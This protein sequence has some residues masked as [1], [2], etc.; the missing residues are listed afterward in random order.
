MEFV[1]QE[2]AQKVLDCELQ[3]ARQLRQKQV[4]QQA[5]QWSEDRRRLFQE[6]KIRQKQDMAKQITEQVQEYAKSRIEHLLTAHDLAVAEVG[7]AHRAAAHLRQVEADRRER[8]QELEAAADERGNAAIR[9]AL[10]AQKKKEE[11]RSESLHRREQV[12]KEEDRKAKEMLEKSRSKLNTRGATTVSGDRLPLSNVANT[13]TTRSSSMKDQSA[14]N[15]LKYPG[16]VQQTPS[17]PKFLTKP[18]KH[19][20]GPTTPSRTK[21]V[22]SKHANIT[23]AGSAFDRTAKNRSK[24]SNRTK[25]MLRYTSTGTVVPTSSTSLTKQS[26]TPSSTKPSTSGPGKQKVPASPSVA[27]RNGT[28]TVRYFDTRMPRPETNYTAPTGLAVR[29]HDH[30]GRHSPDAW[31]KAEAI[32][33]LSMKEVE[34]RAKHQEDLLRRTEERGKVARKKAH[35]EK[36]L[37]N[38]KSEL[39][40]GEGADA[41]TALGTGR[42]ISL[43]DLED[44][45]P[46]PRFG[47]HEMMSG[48]D[49]G[50]KHESLDR[51]HGTLK[52]FKVNDKASGFGVDLTRSKARSKGTTKTKPKPKEELEN[53]E[54]RS[55]KI[56]SEIVDRLESDIEKLK[57]Q[58]KIL[59]HDHGGVISESSRIDAIDSSSHKQASKP[60]SPRHASP[61]GRSPSPKMPGTGSGKKSDQSKPNQVFKMD[62]GSDTSSLTP[63]PKFNTAQQARKKEDD[64][65]GLKTPV[66]SGQRRIIVP[67]KSRSK[68]K[69]FKKREERLVFS[70]SHESI[71][72]ASD[73]EKGVSESTPISSA[74]KLITI[75]SAKHM[76]NKSDVLEMSSINTTTSASITPD[77]SPELPINKKHVKIAPSGDKSVG[78]G[79]DGPYTS[80]PEGNLVLKKPS[81]RSVAV[82]VSKKDLMLHHIVSGFLTRRMESIELM[83]VS[84]SSSS[85]LHVDSSLIT[86]SPS[87]TGASTS[88][89]SPFG[90]S[91]SSAHTSTENK[92]TTSHSSVYRTRTYENLLRSRTL[93]T[94]TSTTTD[95]DAE[96]DVSLTKAVKRIPVHKNDK[97]VA[98]STTENRGKGSITSGSTLAEATVR[99]IIESTSGSSYST[100]QGTTTDTTTNTSN[101]AVENTPKSH[102]DL[103]LTTTSSNSENS[104]LHNINLVHESTGPTNTDNTTGGST[105]EP[106]LSSQ[107]TTSLE[108]REIKRAAFRNLVGDMID[109]ED[110]LSPIC[111]HKT[112]EQPDILATIFEKLQEDFIGLMP[113]ERPPW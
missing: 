95:T 4:R 82:A 38:L 39:L 56:A 98:T 105:S 100:N 97:A 99:T 29:E 101:G 73:E 74:D 16:K 59:V 62:T 17:K 78:H 26:T 1:V 32:T 21:S 54:L 66:A 111:P 92:S 2:A 58:M 112:Q 40:S 37:I 49:A 11:M 72:V 43:L 52:K 33:K 55:E 65:I 51:S 5:S 10:K 18:K 23:P 96:H 68:D 70:P 47:D 13:V 3:K 103:A 89:H 71:I 69:T 30:H 85:D 75:R 22:P 34:E 41:E 113:I 110:F 57:K 108:S 46:H 53:D 42:Q 6:E 77:G 8:C 27:T 90:T 107:K 14:A 20:Y 87:S 9:E 7:A 63:E 104:T 88:F 19:G 12:R 48:S 83:P 93:V 24:A 25:G 45:A 64:I 86:R 91:A 15:R 84:S 44:D 61:H 36:K 60:K 109:Y 28:S 81:S 76:S 35:L 67:K 80:T 102:H 31:N 94:A 106:T 79:P 50:S